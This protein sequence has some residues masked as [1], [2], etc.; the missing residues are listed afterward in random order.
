MAVSGEEQR[1]LECGTQAV[2]G[3][4]LSSG[5]SLTLSWGELSGDLQ[6]EGGDRGT[7]TDAVL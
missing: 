4:G 7:L 2:E 1:K 6:G 3:S 5:P